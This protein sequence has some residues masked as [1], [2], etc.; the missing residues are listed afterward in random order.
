MPFS[1]CLFLFFLFFPTNL[2]FFE[3]Y[4][5]KYFFLSFSAS[6]LYLSLTFSLYLLICLFFYSLC[7]FLTFFLSLSLS[8]F[9]YLFFSLSHY[10]IRFFSIYIF[11]LH[12]GFTLINI[13]VMSYSSTYSRG[14][15]EKCARFCVGCFGAKK[16]PAG[17][18]HLSPLTFPNFF[19][20]VFDEKWWRWKGKFFPFSLIVWHCMEKFCMQKFG[21]NSNLSNRAVFK[22]SI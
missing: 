14:K 22:K 9:T 11:F 18:R 20:H 16:S 2:S 4:F 10:S 15:L 1:L 13:S 5:L 12:C 19:W 8:H 6:L 3:Y 17:S 7:L 21:K